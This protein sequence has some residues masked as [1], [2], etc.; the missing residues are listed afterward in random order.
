MPRRLQLFVKL[1]VLL[2][3]H[4]FPHRRLLLAHNVVLVLR[5]V[6]NRV[7]FG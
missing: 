2:L 6:A 4:L 7:G 1:M 3:F 5:L